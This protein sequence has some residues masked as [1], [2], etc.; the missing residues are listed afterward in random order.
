MCGPPPFA[1]REVLL[2]LT[3]QMETTMAAKPLLVSVN[4]DDE[5][6]E[7]QVRADII[8]ETEQLAHNM[9]VEQVKSYA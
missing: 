9:Q 8:P 6:E 1:F 3:N 2:F 7:A 5:G 4:N